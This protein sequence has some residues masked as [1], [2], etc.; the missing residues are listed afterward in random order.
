MEHRREQESD[1]DFLEATGDPLG[2]QI[3]P[4]PKRLQDI[5]PAYRS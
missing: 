2:I 5:R 3:D 1:A 4:H